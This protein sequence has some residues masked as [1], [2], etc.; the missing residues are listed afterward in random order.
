MRLTTKTS[1]FSYSNGAVSC[2]GADV[3]SRGRL[4]SSS[5][6][7]NGCSQFARQGSSI[8]KAVV[9]WL[10]NR[11]ELRT[12]LSDHRVSPDNNGVERAV[13]AATVYRKAALFK[14]SVEGA[15]AYCNLLILRETAKLNGIK[16]VAGWHRAV[17]R[18]FYEYVE[19]T[20]WTA[21]CE[22][23]RSGEPLRLRLQG[24]PAEVIESFDWKPWLPWNY[25]K[26]LA[27]D[28]RCTPV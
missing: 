8:G 6:K 5:F 15:K 25:A 9:F 12:F 16:D 3:D 27:A 20:V 14:Q 10:N 13:R 19:R 26:T 1:Q 24:I 7:N 23:L 17:H 22:R 21:R 2:C 28:E 18:A 11:K 4:A